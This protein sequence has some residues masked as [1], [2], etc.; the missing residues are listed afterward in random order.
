MSGS[1]GIRQVMEVYVGDLQV[2]RSTLKPVLATAT[3]AA[4]L[5]AFDVAQADTRCA[6][7]MTDWQPRDAVARMAEQNGWKVRRIKIDDGCY[8]VIGSDAKGR[9]LEVKVHP[10]T[11]ALVEYE[12]DADD[13][14]AGDE[15]D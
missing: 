2:K 8:E 9:K 3:L 13:D 12:H 4:C 15:T 1:Q 7:P 5:L 11:L 6:V 14:R 10:G